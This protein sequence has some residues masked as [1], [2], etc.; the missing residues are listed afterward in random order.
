MILAKLIHDKTTRW[1]SSSAFINFC[2]KNTQFNAKKLCY[3]KIA[4][5]FVV[6][7]PSGVF[8]C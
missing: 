5:N 2:V 8:D 1:L 7:L 3:E 4:V 6:V